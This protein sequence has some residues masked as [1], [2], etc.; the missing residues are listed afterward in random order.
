ME[1]EKK[2]PEC[3]LNDDELNKYGEAMIPV[4]AKCKISIVGANQNTVMA[5][6]YL[7]D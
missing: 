1:P 3:Y 7:L 6:I 2:Y 4:L 5:C